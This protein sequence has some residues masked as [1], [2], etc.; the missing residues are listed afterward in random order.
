MKGFTNHKP[1]WLRS[2]LQLKT[3]R[4]AAAVMEMETAR[5]YEAAL[6][7]TTDI[8]TRKLLGDLAEIERQHS[9]LAE[10]LQEEGIT[11]TERAGGG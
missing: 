3:A 2:N 11:Q 1:F 7:R 5:F 8:G 9:G 10:S 6:L 4:N